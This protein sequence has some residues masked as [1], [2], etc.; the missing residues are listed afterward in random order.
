MKIGE[1]MAL[2]TFVMGVTGIALVAYRDGG[3]SREPV[4]GEGGARGKK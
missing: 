1:S 2:V 3:V 4:A